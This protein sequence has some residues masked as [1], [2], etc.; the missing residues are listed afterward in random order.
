MNIKDPVEREAV[1]R[2]YAATV[3]RLQQRYEDEKLGD[4]TRQRDLEEQWRP[5]VKS[6]DKV[7]EKVSKVLESI[8]EGVLNIHQSLENRPRKSVVMEFED[9]GPEVERFITRNKIHDP[10]LDRTFGIRFS[11][12]GQTVIG[13]TPITIQGDDIIINNEVYHGTR[14]LWSLIT[15]TK[16][17][18]IKNAKPTSN[19]KNEYA[20]MLYQTGV[21]H[22]G[23]KTEN[24][25]PRSNGSWKWKKLLG[26]IWRKFKTMNDSSG[27]GLIIPGCH[28]Y[29]QKNGHCRLVRKMGKGLYLEPHH[30]DL[31]FGD[32][33][34]I[35]TPSSNLYEGKGIQSKFPLLNI[36]E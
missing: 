2:D 7:T 33:L 29:F 20:A 11:T 25:T 35:K 16:E 17:D 23:I 1:V 6:Q 32:G 30:L 8:R 22:E 36:L 14:G 13:N 12:D 28:L 24:N 27:R 9:L 26:P 3:E 21:L 15:D 10:T 5:V 34:Y 31:E 18:Q 19:D 4:L